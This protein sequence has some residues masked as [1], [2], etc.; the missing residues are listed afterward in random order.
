[1]Q[2]NNLFSLKKE[3][4][5]A[6]KHVSG[7]AKYTDDILEPKNL[8]HGA[9]GYSTI[10]KGRIK[11]IDLTEVINSKGVEKVITYRDIPGVNDVG[12]IFK[13][14]PIFTENNIEYYG[15]PIFAVAAKT[16]ELARKAIKKAKI[17]YL[18]K[19]P[20]LNIDDAIKKKSFV[21]K[22]VKISKGNAINEIKKSKH[23]LEGELYSGG[24]DHFYLE[25]QISMTIPQED[26]NFLVYASTQ[27]PSET[28]QIVAKSINQKFNYHKK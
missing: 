8:L 10:A 24:Q 12:P 19:K 16:N 7:K 18:E 21:L 6:K 26:N 1:M 20:I 15:Q 23:T 4:E 14:D 3:H 2:S 25:G 17:Q 9:I 13:G 28:Q 22:P 11:K 5:S 27:H